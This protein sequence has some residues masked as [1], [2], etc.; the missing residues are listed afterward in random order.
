MFATHNDQENF[1]HG[2]QQ[3]AASKPLNQGTRGAPPKTP[4]NKY[5]KT[6]LRVPLNDENAPTGYGGGGKSVLGTKKGNENLM[7]GGKKGTTFDK[8]AFV[9]P[10]GTWTCL[11]S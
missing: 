6:P 9:T 10:M 5:P 1:V 11:N 4:G 8:N 3:V 7:T 2:H